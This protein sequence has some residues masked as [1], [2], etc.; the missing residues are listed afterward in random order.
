MNTADWPFVPPTAADILS[1]SGLVTG[2]GEA[3]PLPSAAPPGSFLALYFSAH[4]CPPC[5][6]FTPKLAAAYKKVKAGGAKLEVAFVSSDRDKEGFDEYFAEMP[7]LAVPFED[8]DAKAKLSALFE[9]RGIPTL[10]LLDDKLRLVNP[11]ARGAVEA[12]RD[13]PWVRT[14]LEWVACRRRMAGPLSPP[15][16]LARAICTR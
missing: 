10:I 7:W 14:P 4:W 11:D 2:K 16:C 13:F 8:R 1:K 3:V 15:L 6:G 5:R 9:V 12:G